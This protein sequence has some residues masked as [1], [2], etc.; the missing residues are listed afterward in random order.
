MGGGKTCS[1]DQPVNKFD[2]K[3]EIVANRTKNLKQNVESAFADPPK[4]D[5]DILL[6]H[7]WIWRWC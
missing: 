4:E 5:L 3:E 6:S 7:S 1:S 2:G